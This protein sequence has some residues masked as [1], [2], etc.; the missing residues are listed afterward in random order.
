MPACDAVY[1]YAPGMMYHKTCGNDY[2]HKVECRPTWRTLF[3]C[4][5]HYEMTLQRHLTRQPDFI[6]YEAIVYDEDN[7]LGLPL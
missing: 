3:L 7:P 1:S 4:D 2:T 5:E 6:V